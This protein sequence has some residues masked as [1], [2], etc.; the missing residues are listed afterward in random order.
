MA[1]VGVVTGVVSGAGRARGL[2]GGELLA[3]G[4]VGGLLYAVTG[5]VIIWVLGGVLG[6]VIACRVACA[7]GA[8]AEPSSRIRKVGQLLIGAVIGPSI[9]T[10]ELPVSPTLLA[11]LAGGVLVTLLASL[12]VA[13]LYHAFA[14]V[15]GLTAGLATLPGGIGIMPS[16]A[17]EYRRPVGLVAVVQSFRM[18]L[19]LVTALVVFAVSAGPAGGTP[20]TER[21]L[22]PASWPGWTYLVA[23]LGGSVVAAWAAGRLRVPVPTLLGPLVYGALLSLGLRAFGTD[24]ELLAAP[25]LQEILGQILLGVTVGEYLAQRYRDGRDALVGGLTGVVVTCGVAL[26]IA[27]G[28][29]AVGPWSFLTAFLMVAPGGAPEMV[30]IAAATGDGDL[31]LVLAAQTGRQV[32]VNILMPAWIRLFD[33]FDR[34]GRSRCPDP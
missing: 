1:T 17:A 15:D 3:A 19:V 18:T 27:F 29:S 11:V 31:A 28:M 20:A 8:P 10:Q 13:R 21:S 23:L 9:A 2:L 22:L 26:L 6:A 30:V 24:P 14:P 5:Q 34:P 7:A 12:G 32:L 4:V 25:F 33:R 16:V